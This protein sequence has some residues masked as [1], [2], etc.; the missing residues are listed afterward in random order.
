MRRLS[1]LSF[2][3][4]VGVELLLA[5]SILRDV[6][7]VTTTRLHLNARIDGTASDASERFDIEASRVVPQIAIR[8][9]ERIAFRIEN[10]WPSTL[11]V[12]A[13]PA[14]P[15]ALCHSRSPGRAAAAR[16]ARRSRSA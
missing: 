13:C 8:H 4:F 9:D 12:R 2:R 14:A 3:V 11:H 6:A 5:L 7:N 15:A 16:R 10:P 1:R